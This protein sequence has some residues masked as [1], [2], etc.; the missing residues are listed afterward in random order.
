MASAPKGFHENLQELFSH[1][2]FVS[3]LYI[4]VRKKPGLTESIHLNIAALE[5]AVG[6]VLNPLEL[7]TI[8]LELLR[9]AAVMSAAELT[10]WC[11]SSRLDDRELLLSPAPPPLPPPP[12]MVGRRAA[13]SS[14]SGGGGRSGKR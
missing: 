8:G 6:S 1:I 5:A 13:G 14:T 9:A 11:R 7:S 12:Q 2:G 3:S 4:F 10:H